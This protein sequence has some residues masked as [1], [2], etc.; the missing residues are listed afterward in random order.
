MRRAHSVMKWKRL[1]RSADSH[2]C[3][4]CI[5]RPLQ[6]TDSRSDLPSS[7]GEARSLFPHALG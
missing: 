5:L 2:G 4:V 1:L 6:A 3:S 7:L